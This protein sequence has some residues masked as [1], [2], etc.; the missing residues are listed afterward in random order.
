MMDLDAF[1]AFNDTRGHP[2]GDAL[3][4]GI[5][6]EMSAAVRDGDRIYRYGGDEFAAILPGADRVVAHDVAERLRRTVAEL[7]SGTPLVSISVGVSCYPDDGRSKDALVAVADRAMYLAKPTAPVADG[8]ALSDDPYL[9]ALDETALALLDRRDGAMLLETIL[10]RACSLLGTPHGYIFIVE[11][12]GLELDLRHGSGLFAQG[13]G[14][15]QPVDKGIGGQVFLTGQ[16]VTVDD[17]DAWARRAGIVPNGMLSAVVGVPLFSGD[18]V[19]GVIGLASS[20]ADRAF[21]Q[22]DVAALTRFAQLASIVIDN[23]RLVDVAE[24][25]ALYDPTTGLPNRELLTD[26]I[27][28]ALSRVRPEDADPIAVIML[29]LDRFKVIN[30]SVGHAVG[31]RL[32]IAV[33][34]RLATCLRPGRHGRPLR[35]RRV[36]DHPRPRRGR[37]RG[38]ADRRDDRIGAARAV[39]AERPRVVHQ[40][41]DR[42]RPRRAGPGH[43]GRAAARG[44]GR[45]GPGQERP[46]GALRAV[47]PVDERADARAHRPRERPPARPRARRA[48]RPLPADRGPPERPDRRLR[49]AG[50]LAAPRAR[51]R[52]A[53]LVHRPGR[54]D[55][56][57][58]AAR[59]LGARDRLPPG[60]RVAGARA[61]PGT[62]S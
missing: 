56:P 15:R 27:A 45:D 43:A 14:H 39:L 18:E 62:R 4:T 12:G 26:R 50:P 22:R 10:T 16:P 9:R 41:L 47:R 33:G 5:A 42:H 59:A 55:R 58:R 11:P 29:D 60:G 61:R 31:D 19:V 49:G 36:R 28:H 53:A 25:G 32:L 7:S 8:A 48:A 54:G 2:A 20:A 44:G 21:G 35:R 3:L 17:Y 38:A 57:D 6:R 30:E 1:K 13:V 37:G 52:P 51:A 46:G 24:R 34:Q 40:R 23:A